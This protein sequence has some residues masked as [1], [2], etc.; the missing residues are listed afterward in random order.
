MACTSCGKNKTSYKAPAKSAKYGTTKPSGGMGK[1][2]ARPVAGFSGYGTKMGASYSAPRQSTNS[3]RTPISH[4]PS[5][6][7]RRH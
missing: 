3:T 1:T 5:G 6:R 4:A 7:T 2:S